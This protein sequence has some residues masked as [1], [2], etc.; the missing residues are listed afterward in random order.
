MQCIFIEKGQ[1]V[2]KVGMQPQDEI[3]IAD[4]FEDE[5]VEEGD[6]LLE[7]TQLLGSTPQA[8]ALLV[9]V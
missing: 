3:K 4:S 8:V 5:T 1:F 2:Y 6:Q 9:V 7:R